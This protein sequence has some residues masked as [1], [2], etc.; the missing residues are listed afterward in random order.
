M[1]VSKRWMDKAYEVM[2][3]RGPMTAAR[4]ADVLRYMGKSSPGA[5]QLS[6]RFRSDPRF[7]E[8]A[9]ERSESG[10]YQKEKMWRAD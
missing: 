9:R 6:Q 10:A 4:C 1:V 5:R 2:K 3:E 7:R 8:S